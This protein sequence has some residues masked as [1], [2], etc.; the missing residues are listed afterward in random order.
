MRVYLLGYMGSGKTTVGQRLAVRLNLTF[1]DLDQT[2]EKRHKKTISDWFETSG[3]EAGFRAAEA[4]AL[5][6][7]SLQEKTLIATGGGTPCFSDNMA[8][9]KR[10][11]TT[12]YLE[13]TPES[14]LDRLDREKAS[15]PLIA[16]KSTGELLRFIEQHLAQRQLYYKQAHI[17][18]NGNCVNDE[19]LEDMAHKIRSFIP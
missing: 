6:C 4:A 17:T 9:M 11:G 10:Y 19:A 12:V 1:T 15:R 18:V 8:Y 5:R 2:I 13:M 16:G 3:G 7:I 14:L